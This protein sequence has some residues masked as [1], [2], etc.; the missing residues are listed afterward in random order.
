MNIADCFACPLLEKADRPGQSNCAG[1]GHSCRKNPG[2]VKVVH[3]RPS[4]EPKSTCGK[5][6]G[7]TAIADARAT[8][9]ACVMRKTTRLSPIPL[10]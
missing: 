4:E 9:E 10:S 1:I 7:R 6:H 5:A 3:S 8:D 2:G